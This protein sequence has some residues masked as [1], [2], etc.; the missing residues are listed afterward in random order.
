MKK[1]LALILALSSL[2]AAPQAPGPRPAPPEIRLVLL[3]AVD[4]FRYDYLTRFRGEFTS[5]FKRLLTQGAVFTDANLEHYPTVTAIGHATM[6]TGA[7]P[8]VSGIIGNDWFDRETGTQVQSITDTTV[9][10]VGAADAATASPRRLLV[11]TVGDELKLSAGAPKGSDAAPRV[12]GLSLKDRSA[13]MPAGRGADAAYW[14]DTKSGAF[15]SST[16]YMTDVPAWVK[17][18]N[19]RH[20]A[21]THLGQEWTPLSPPAVSLKQLPKERGT[22]FYEAVFG[23]PFGNEL[24]L[25]FATDALTHER[26]GQ[27]G[28]TD[29]MSVSFSSNDS[30]GHNYGPQSPQVRDITIRTDRIIG[31]LLDR[32]DKTVGLQHTL[33]ALTADHGVAPLPEDLASRSMPG[34]RMANKELFGAIQKELEAK[35]GPGEWLASTAG[36]SPY[37]N[38]GLIAE[39]K[40]SAEEVRR[41]AADAALAVPHVTRVYTR[42]QL[43][44]GDVGDDRIGR[45][46]VR[47]FN[48]QRSGDLE[49]ILEPFWMRATSG[50]THGT[51][52]NYDA[53]IPLVLMGPPI[54][55]GVYSDPV[56][57]NDLAPTLATI[58]NVQPPS[59]SSGRVLT[60]AIKAPA[61]TAEAVTKKSR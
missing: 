5:G 19:D 29:L 12:I 35:Y 17:A 20:L 24:L 57:L 18:F 30:V 39:K 6:L 22:P 23:S 56:A 34:G 25:A 26:M 44:R 7:T 54:K 28:V 58:L 50:T 59:G 40:L 32:V 8:S 51:P 48:V 60:E 55:P 14:L 15:V 43:L 36:S 31:Q 4:Q 21:D 45:R 41:V 9:K 2:A 33:I 10:P 47:G 53:H 11:S 13:V 16:Y 46:V 42:D 52:Y 49:I 1:L 61:A 27:R 38:Y 37:L 3:I